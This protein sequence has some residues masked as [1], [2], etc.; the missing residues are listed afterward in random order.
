M[1]KTRFWGG[2]QE[3]HPPHNEQQFSFS[4]FSV[5][6]E[7]VP[8]EVIKKIVTLPLLLCETTVCVGLEGLCP[9]YC[10]ADRQP[11][12]S[13]SSWKSVL[14]MVFLPLFLVR[15]RTVSWALVLHGHSFYTRAAGPASDE[16]HNSSSSLE[17]SNHQ[18]FH[19]SSQLNYLEEKAV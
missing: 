19:K 3:L 5:Q 10:D 15:T 14:Y 1:T 16:V 2:W 13:H 12:P 9:F 8:F 17:S 7:G 6:K 4:F 11:R 18:P